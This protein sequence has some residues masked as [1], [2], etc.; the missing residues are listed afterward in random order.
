CVNDVIVSGAEPLFFLDYYATSKLDNNVAAAVVKSIAAG[1]KRAGAALVGGETAEMPGMYATGDF[2]LAGFCVGVVEYDARIDG[3][4][5]AAGDVVLGLG[6]SGAHSNGYSL[7]RRVLEYSGA[8]LDTAL[9][10]ST[11]RD[12]LLAP[13]RIYVP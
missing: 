6:S 9:G 5:V 10:D 1:C 3:S 8:S 2:D 12:A 13:T 7:V 4:R 11:L